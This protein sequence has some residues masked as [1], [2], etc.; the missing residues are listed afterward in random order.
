LFEQATTFDPQYAAAY[1]R[2]GFVYL[3]EGMML[4]PDPQLVR[5]ALEMSQKAVNLDV[6]LPLAHT[7]LGTISLF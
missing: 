1:A 6:A 5:R 3:P 2:L 4:R 7:T